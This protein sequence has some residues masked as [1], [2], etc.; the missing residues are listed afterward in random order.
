M[1]VIVFAVALLAALAAVVVGVAMVSPAAGWII[2]GVGGA[3]W[4]YLVLADDTEP[5]A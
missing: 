2:G 4:A 5:P 3:G 1:R